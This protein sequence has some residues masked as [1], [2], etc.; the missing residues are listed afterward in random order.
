[1]KNLILV[2]LLSL[3]SLAAISQNAEK[4]TNLP[5]VNIKTLD[6]QTFNTQDIT[7]DG[8]PVIISFWALW[9][10]PCKKELDAFNENFNQFQSIF[11][12]IFFLK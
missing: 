4:N 6:G 11:V 8:K 7:N 9:C 12:L 3:L 10:K 5:S 2:S 1:M